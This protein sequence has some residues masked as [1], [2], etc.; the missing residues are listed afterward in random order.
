MSNYPQSA[1]GAWYWDGRRWLPTGAAPAT[2]LGSF[3]G[4]RGGSYWDGRELFVRSPRAAVV[5]ATVLL[6]LVTVLDL[7]VLVLLAGLVSPAVPGG[8][9]T[10]FVGLGL[11]EA[12]DIVLIGCWAYFLCWSIRPPS[13]H[14]S[15]RGILARQPWRGAFFIPWD[16]VVQIGTHRRTRLLLTVE[17]SEEFWRY[18]GRRW[19]PRWSAPLTR[20]FGGPPRGAGM[21][22]IPPG[23][24]GMEMPDILRC[25]RRLA[26]ARIP[27]SEEPVG[28][29]A[30]PIPRS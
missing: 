25:V 15:G 23:G 5:F 3:L 27:V 20:A 17:V 1:D 13:V 28:A 9:S 12:G 10:A 26:P 6:G 11:L 16:A 18:L 21:I 30:G 14:F 29:P 8:L 22:A 24:T 19:T 7:G 2:P 4:R